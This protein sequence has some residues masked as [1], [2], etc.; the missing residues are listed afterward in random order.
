VAS[1]LLKDL[2]ELRAE[3]EDQMT[4]PPAEPRFLVRKGGQ[5]DEWM[6]WDRQRRGPAVL[7]VRQAT[8]LS[9]E[10][11]RKFLEQLKQAYDED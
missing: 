6:V 2:V 1:I 5:R 10:Q 3:G 11:A 7:D 8:G 4:R 9:E